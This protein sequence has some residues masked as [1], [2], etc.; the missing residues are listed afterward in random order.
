MKLGDVIEGSV[1]PSSDHPFS[2]WK[3]P[4]KVRKIQNKANSKGV[5]VLARDINGQ[6]HFY[7]LEAA[8]DGIRVLEESAEMSPLALSARASYNV[9]NNFDVRIQKADSLLE[10]LTRSQYAASSTSR[11]ED[12][13]KDISLQSI[14]DANSLMMEKLLS[15]A[16][17][18]EEDISNWNKT[19][20]SNGT[21]T[22][23]SNAGHIRGTFK[24]G[25][26]LR[27]SEAQVT[28]GA[29][30][31]PFVNLAPP[32]EVSER[33]FSLLEA[34]NNIGYRSSLEQIAELQHEFI[35]IHPFTDGNGR[36]SRIFTDFLLMKA[37]FPPLPH[38]YDETRV[39]L[40]HSPEEIADM[41]KAAYKGQAHGP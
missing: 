41:W 17:L 2:W 28:T 40:F 22:S 11:S 16:P 6:A 14:S 23:A 30:G 4:L 15:G 5:H 20:L 13:T 25:R 35:A 29:P 12:S 37:H 7:S 27:K 19:L 1:I 21:N 8:K 31:I 3:S 39:I 10:R 26:D 33:L 18:T 9:E 32:H 36:T 24:E 38:S 34:A